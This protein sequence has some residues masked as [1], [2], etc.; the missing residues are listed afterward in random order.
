MHIVHLMNIEYWKDFHFLN[1]L[2]F[3]LQFW[4]DWDLFIYLYLIEKDY[5]F[6]IFY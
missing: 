1:S 5:P 3:F 4:V 2:L 6:P